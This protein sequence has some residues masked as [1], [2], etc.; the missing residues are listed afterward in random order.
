LTHWTGFGPSTI[1]TYIGQQ[2]TERREYISLPRGRF[3]PAMPMLECFMKI[4]I[5]NGDNCNRF[6]IIAGTARLVYRLEYGL[7]DR[8]IRNRFLTG[9]AIFFSSPQVPDRPWGPSSLLS[10]VYWRLFPRGLSGQ[11]VKMTTC[12]HLVPR[13]KMSGS[14]PPLPRRLHDVVFN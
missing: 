14:T 13:L 3:E 4:S 2:Y 11:G 9:Q 7:D 6:I 5:V 10:N 12:P 1:S 8:G